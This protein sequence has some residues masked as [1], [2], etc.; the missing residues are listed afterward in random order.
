MQTAWRDIL[1]AR[2]QALDRPTV[3]GFVAWQNTPCRQAPCSAGNLR[4]SLS[5]DAYTHAARRYTNSESPTGFLHPIS[6]AYN[7][8]YSKLLLHPCLTELKSNYRITTIQLLT[9]HIHH[10][11]ILK[12][13]L[14][15]IF[16]SIH[17]D[18]FSSYNLYSMPSS[19]HHTHTFDTLLHTC[20]FLSL[21]FNLHI[22]HHEF[23]I[24][25][26][27]FILFSTFH[28]A[29]LKATIHLSKNPFS[30]SINHIALHY[31][32]LSH[33]SIIIYLLAKTNIHLTY[34]KI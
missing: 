3:S 11:S 25:N 33:H 27:Y 23:Y 24:L 13:V 22:Q 28:S 9:A 19:H 17:H 5:P 34:H 14:Y 16:L 7:P 15:Q 2:C 1:V 32:I 21:C 8:K 30:I 4:D 10:S 6:L 18:L 26:H 20:T 29:F 12:C 31:R